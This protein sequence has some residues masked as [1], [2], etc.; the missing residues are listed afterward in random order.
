MNNFKKRKLGGFDSIKG[1]GAIGIGDIV[2]K[3]RR[4]RGVSEADFAQTV[5]LTTAQIGEIESYA[6]TPDND[7]IRNLANSS[8]KEE[9]K[10]TNINSIQSRW[11]LL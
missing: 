9:K 11:C 10:A 8:L 3:A 6:F 1:I 2:G 5:G 7:G 4:G